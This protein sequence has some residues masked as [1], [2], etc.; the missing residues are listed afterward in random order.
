[1]IDQA[2]FDLIKSIALA[3]SKYQLLEF[4]NVLSVTVLGGDLQLD[5]TSIEVLPNKLEEKIFSAINCS[6]TQ[7]QWKRNLRVETKRSIT[8]ELSKTVTSSNE[9][10]VGVSLGSAANKFNGDIAAK[11]SVSIT[12]KDS[13]SFSETIVEDIPEDR[14]IPPKTALYTKQQ[15]S[16]GL[17]KGK[18]TG[19]VILTASVRM[20]I[21]LG[22]TNYTEDFAFED[23]RFFNTEPRYRTTP[24]SGFIYGEGY[25]RTDIIYKERTV[26]DDEPICSFGDIAA[27]RN[28]LPHVEDGPNGLILAPS[29]LS[30]RNSS[31]PLNRDSELTIRLNNDD[32]GDLYI[33]I[34]DNNTFGAP[35]I[36]E[37]DRLNSGETREISI[38][39]SG[40]GDGNIAWRAV[41][42][43]DFTE[44]REERSVTVSN[45]DRVDLTTQFG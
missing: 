8:T 13:Q 16:K 36:V 30:L 10:K 28:R 9:Y 24:V 44:A 35:A 26:V 37:G 6:T 12:S 7:K 18:V 11:N 32:I 42:V 31:S 22:P 1:M 34:W 40:D 27:L 38:A 33:W 14:L 23:S 4:H 17:V 15:T 2:T 3:T 19:T 20:T 43:D 21:R 45:G 29:E 25:E 39:A 5:E 41:R